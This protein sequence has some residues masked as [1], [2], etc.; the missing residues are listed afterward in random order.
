MDWLA[1]IPTIISAVSTIKS[2]V[3]IAQSNLEVVEKIKAAA[4]TVADALEAYGA[5]FFPN[6]KPELHIAAAAM[7]AFDP[8]VTKWLQGSLNALLD[9]SPDLRVDGAYGPK[10]KFAVQR[11]QEQLGLSPDGWAGNL[12]QSAI[13]ALL[14]KK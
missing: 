8:N 7:T 6:A 1:L 12:T 4:P 11:L 10:T 9:P 13:M 14:T 2:I 3:D 5:Q